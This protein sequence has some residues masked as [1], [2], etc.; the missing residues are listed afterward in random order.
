M[1]RTKQNPV[2]ELPIKTCLACGGTWFREV[3]HHQFLTEDQEDIT[4]A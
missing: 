4:T 2:R 3:I 1:D